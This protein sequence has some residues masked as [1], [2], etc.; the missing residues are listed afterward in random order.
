NTQSGSHGWR[1]DSNLTVAARRWSLF[2]SA[3]AQYCSRDCCPHLLALLIVA[4]SRGWL[5]RSFVRA[6]TVTVQSVAVLPLGNLSGDQEQD[7][8]PD[9]MTDELITMLA[10]TS[11]LRVCEREN[12]KAA[13]SGTIAAL[14]SQY[15][16]SLEAV[17]CRSATHWL[18][19]RLRR[20]E[21]KGS[22]RISSAAS[23][24]REKLGESL[25]SIQKF[26]KPV[27][28]VTTSSL[29]ALKA[30]TQGAELF[31]SG[32]Q[33]K[34]IPF[35]ERAKELDPN[36]AAAY[37]ELASIYSNN[38]EEE[39]SLE[40]E[41]KA[42]ALRDR[43]SEREK[44]AITRAYHWMVTGELDK[45]METE[46]MWRQAY[47]RDTVPLNDL[48]VNHAIFLGSSRRARRRPTMRSGLALM[49]SPSLMWLQ[50][51]IWHRTVPMRPGRF[52]TPG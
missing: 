41:K 6:S 38:G 12:I 40:Y 35:F 17:N 8:F 16:M 34:A 19:S 44:L 37:G 4:W 23:R 39:R 43:V 7:F 2:G 10:K 9:G 33:L 26:D 48:A 52:S 3:A 13:L 47:P 21:R 24:L 42:F 1:R 5:N 29:G 18:A 31:G 20:R 15:V 25:A 32:Q 22:A 28:E 51:R 11:S 14:G 45:E 36:F 50:L 27:E 46:E 49:S 30:Y